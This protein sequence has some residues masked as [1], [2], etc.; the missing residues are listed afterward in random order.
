[1]EIS[2]RKKK[3]LI[4]GL[5]N[6]GKSTI[7]D[8]IQNKM[9]DLIS[10]QPTR[11]LSRSEVEIFG[12][13][14]MIHDLGG[15]KVYRNQYL[16]QSKYFEATDAYVFVVDM[17][18]KERYGLALE[19]FKKSLKLM[20]S[21]DF[22]PKTFIFFHK[23]DKQFLDEYNE[24]TRVK[25]E[26]DSLQAKFLHVAEK[27]HVALD[28]IFKTSVYNEWSCY[29]AFYEIWTSI[30]PPLSNVQDYLSLI[31]HEIPKLQIALLLDEKADLMAKKLSP[32]H[33]GREK[34]TNTNL[35]NHERIVEIAGKSINLMNEWVQSGQYD[36]D[37]ELNSATVKIKD[38]TVL[39]RKF[40]GKEKAY[41]LVL[42]LEG[43]QYSLVKDKISRMCGSISA[44][45]SGK[46]EHS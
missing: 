10:I 8:L 1:M 35:P 2:E 5:D 12:Q 18:D 16:A 40:R 31:F 32:D 37:Q 15:Q 38:A 28:G 39:V 30:N 36:Q 9:V 21:L 42:M 43:G 34:D 7:L 27:S 22:S 19:Y 20:R 23:H 33:E 13:H 3:I 11:G 46:K 45:L 44:F 29:S 4:V 17:Q 25:E 26:C 41:F 6:A 24:K 14:I